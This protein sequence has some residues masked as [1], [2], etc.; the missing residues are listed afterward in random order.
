MDFG[1]KEIRRLL[2]ILMIVLLGILV[3]IVVKPVLL[4]V[5]AG[6]ILG[7]VFFPLYRRTLRYVREKNTAA[8][9]VSLV[10]VAFIV[11]PL[12]F[13]VPI[14]VQQIFEI[15]KF[16]QTLDVQ[17]FVQA[18]FSTAPE[19][20]IA[21]LTITVSSIIGKATSATLNSLTDWLINIPTI[22][23]QFFIVAFVF[24]FT[25]R[26][27]DK[28]RDMVSAISPLHKNQEKVMIAQFKGI[29]DSL[30]YGQVIVGL[31]Q[32]MFAGLGFLIFGV[33]NAIIL[34]VVAIVFSIIPFVGPG[35]VWLP[36]TVY[37]FAAGNNTAGALYLA[38]NLIIVS[39]V[40]NILRS[41]IVSRKA[42]ISPAV[43]MVGMI[44]GLFIFGALGL[45]IGP[46]ILAY[47]TTFLRAY[48]EKTL[49]SLFAE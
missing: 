13:L 23:L 6:L 38:Y 1:D 25:L 8:A 22:A 42:D 49:A 31:V 4:S 12:W 37:M 33:Q 2:V 18:L 19:P 44:G 10:I 30:I 32:G 46:L 28:L 9:L 43:V 11:I 15:F 39:T 27:S 41:Y 21:Q 47:F 17:K 45:I 29:T 48:K 3:F 26:D 24:F 35:I 5:I 20:F 36:I 14:M 7:Y 34:T 16:T 40:D